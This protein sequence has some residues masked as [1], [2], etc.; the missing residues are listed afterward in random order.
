[1]EEKK[2]KILI[3]EDQRIV[4]LDLKRTLYN[5]GYSITGICSTGEDA[6]DLIPRKKPDLILMDIL[7][8][9]KMNGIETAECINEKYDIPIIYITALTDVDTYIKAVKTEPRKYLMKPF[10]T[11]SLQKAIAEVFGVS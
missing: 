4:A 9:G 8:K 6:I 1:M 3:V 2:K 10:E 5:C 11:D 7:L